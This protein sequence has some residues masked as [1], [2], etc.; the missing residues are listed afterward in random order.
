MKKRRIS[1]LGLC[2][3]LGAVTMSCEKEELKPAEGKPTT[4]HTKSGD[5]DDPVIRGRVK[6]KSNGMGISG[7]HVETLTYGTNTKV[8]DEYTDSSGD[9]VEV[10]PVGIYY[11]KV[12]VPGNGTPT[13]S[14]TVH[15]NHDVNVTIEV[16][17]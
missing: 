14:D 13:Y 5:D 12:T 8:G 6:K 17:D 16:A 1:V 2:I 11:F 4:E 10:V 15:V 7:A 9:F 3:A